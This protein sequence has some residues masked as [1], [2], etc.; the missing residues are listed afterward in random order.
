MPKNETTTCAE[1]GMPVDNE[2][3]PYAA[4]LM[5]KSCHNS[6]EVKANLKAVLDEGEA[7]AY[8]KRSS[9]F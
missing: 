9:R 7:L 3:H 8:A 2:Y 5:F 1:C 4:C 6:E